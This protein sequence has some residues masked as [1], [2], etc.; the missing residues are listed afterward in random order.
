[1]DEKSVSVIDNPQGLSSSFLPST[2]TQKSVSLTYTKNSILFMLN[3]NMR[4]LSDTD[5]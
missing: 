1:M 4:F 3:K 2:Y 5:L